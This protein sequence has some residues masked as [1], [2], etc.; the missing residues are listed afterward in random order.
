MLYEVTNQ[1]HPFKEALR[2]RV[3]EAGTKLKRKVE[4]NI[5]TLI[6]G[7]GYKGRHQDVCAR[8]ITNIFNTLFPLEEADSKRV[9]IA[10]S[11]RNN[12]TPYAQLEKCGTN[13]A[14]YKRTEWQELGSYKL[15]VSKFFSNM[16][17]P[18]KISLTNH[19]I[20]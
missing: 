20:S 16:Q 17:P 13:C 7:S 6:T 12:F 11:V 1:R 18:Q 8:A 19:E 4:Q 14:M 10:M 9:I 2:Q 15:V 3:S 5:D